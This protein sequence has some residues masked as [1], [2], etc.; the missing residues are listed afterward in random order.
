MNHIFNSLGSNYSFS[1]ALRALFFCASTAQKQKNRELLLSTLEQRFHATPFLAINGRSALAQYLTNTHFKKGSKVL[2]QAFTCYALEQAIVEVGFIPVYLDID[3][4]TRN[5]SPSDIQR[6]LSSDEEIAFVLLQ[7]TGG[8]PA[9]IRQIHEICQKHHVILIED[10]AQAFGALDEEIVPVGTYADVILL[11]FG[12]DKIIDA[13]T[14]GAILVKHTSYQV[15]PNHNTNPLFARW[16]PIITWCIRMCYPIGVGKILHKIFQKTGALHS[17][18]DE[19]VDRVHQLSDLNVSLVLDALEEH[20]PLSAHRKQMYLEYQKSLEKYS[21]FSKNKG[22]PSHL[23][24]SIL[25]E[26]PT[27]II[28][29]LEKKGIHISDRWYRK[30]VDGGSIFSSQWYQ[31]GTCKTAEHLAQHVLNLPTHRYISIDD[32]RY[33]SKEILQWMHSHAKK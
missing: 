4:K 22:V 24:Y 25:V 29:Y 23:R 18:I 3:E 19:P 26:D 17:P 8:H 5:P 31:T 20:A 14:G 11:S 21:A 16:Y 6:H 7:H 32:V 28:S 10:L 2:V 1:R 30:P 27:Q 33:I 12:R 15:A 13:V 9:H